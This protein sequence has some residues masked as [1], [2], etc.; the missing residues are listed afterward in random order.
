MFWLIF[1]IIATLLRT[2]KYV[3][4]KVALKDIDSL[5]LA[6]ITSLFT[7]ILYSPVFFYSV[8]K[9][10]LAVNNP[11][12]YLAIILSGFFNSLAIYLVM[13]SLKLGEISVA[14]PLRNLQPLFAVIL[15]WLILKETLSLDLIPATILVV[16][17]AI[18][19]HAKEGLNFKLKDKSSMLAI[20]AAFILSMALIADK[21]VTNYLKPLNYVYFIYG[22]MF[23][24]LF[25]FSKFKGKTGKI[26]EFTKNRWKIITLF[27]TLSAGGSFFTFTTISLVEVV[28]V[29]P[30]LRLEVLFSGIFGY[31]Y[32][33]EKNFALKLI[34]GILLL[35]GLILIIT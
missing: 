23:L 15:G 11:T 16:L 31:F 12:V 13:E 24:F 17:G 8:S 26:K 10:P 5:T 7:F 6:T 32:F 4:S 28:K 30:V 18:L 2:G 25:T 22:I 20:A 1:A 19:L 21:Y 29:A 3:V 33:K 34:G 14:I 9:N 27:A 35:L